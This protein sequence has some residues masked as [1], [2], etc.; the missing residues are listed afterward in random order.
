MGSET[1]IIAV[2]PE[3]STGK[4]ACRTRGR[5]PTVSTV[6]WVI[7]RS[8]PKSGAEFTSRDA[9]T[10]KSPADWLTSR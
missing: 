5:P 10:A 9:A 7:P 6:P 3:P 8:I 4:Q 1:K 2:L